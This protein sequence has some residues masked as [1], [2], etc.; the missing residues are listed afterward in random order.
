ML[1]A[2]FMLLLVLFDSL[3]TYLLR[4]VLGVE[5][6]VNAVLPLLLLLWV[7]KWGMRPVVPAMSVTML[8][9]LLFLAFSLGILVIDGFTWNRYA[10]IV[11]AFAAF[12][13]GF[14]AFRW[15]DDEEFYARIFLFAGL[16]YVVICIVALS[17]VVPSL[18][19]VTNAEGYKDGVLI[20][21]PE[22][23]TDQ[24]F[25]VYYLFYIVLAL[26]LPFR[27]V[28]FGLAFLGTVG[29]IFILSQLQTRSGVLLMIALTV[30]CLAAP[31]WKSDL[32]RAKTFLLPV[33]ILAVVAA[34]LDIILNSSAALVDRF[35]NDDYRT[36]AG[37]VFSMTYLFEHIWQ[38]GWWVPQG[39]AHFLAL[40]N[41]IPHFNPTAMFLEGGI[42]GL[43]GWMA[44]WVVP[45]FLLWL[46][47]LR[48]Q[49][50][51]L[52]ILILFA[53]TISM[54]AQLSLNAPLHEHIWLWAGAVVAVLERH[55]T[56][57]QSMPNYLPA[58]EYTSGTQLYSSPRF[59]N[60]CR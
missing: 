8:L 35:V 45:L 31:L 4:S 55:R 53:G 16:V 41:N 6:P 10:K 36:F 42:L 23:T 38:V 40:T 21:R 33:L 12:F 14:L 22:L 39:N 30:M 50:D 43:A 3:F 34:N 27:A 20:T 29:A 1:A 49:L 7:F 52:G 48:Q 18:F 59:E 24:N 32:G 54:F 25:Q 51:A 37:R 13:I 26:T 5:F 44:L 58:A 15:S 2:A 56:S 11:T 46:T 19:P 60:L 9:G 47:M 17:G 57:N 28:R